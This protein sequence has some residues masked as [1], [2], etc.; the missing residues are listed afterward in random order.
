MFDF[1]IGGDVLNTPYQYMMGRGNLVESLPYRDAAHG[2]LTYYFENDDFNGKRIAMTAA[3]GPKGERIYDNGRILPGVKQDGTPNDIIVPVDWYYV[4]AYNWGAADY[5]DYS[6]SIF[7]NSY[8]KLRELSIGYRLPNSITSKFACTSLSVSIYGRN[9]CYLY[10]N[11][12]AFD[13]EATDGTT[14]RSQVTIGGSTAT[15]RS[16]GFSLRANF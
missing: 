12:P 13:S 3:A 4:N 15:T 1:R 6:N 5:V 16:F 10:K 11:L 9:L 2:G 7:D 8:L 14:W